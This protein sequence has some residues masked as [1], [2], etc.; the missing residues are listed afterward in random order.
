MKRGD[1]KTGDIKVGNDK[2][3]DIKNSSIKTGIRRFYVACKKYV[4]IA[5]INFANRLAYKVDMVSDIFFSIFIFSILHFLYRATAGI[6]P[7]SAIEKL[8]L[9]QIMWVMFLATVFSG[10]RHKGVS[11]EL[12]KEILS[13]QIAYQLNR[14]YSYA[15]FHFAQHVG[16]LLPTVIFSGIV[17]GIFLYFLVGLPPLYLGPCLLGTI[18]LFIGVV[19]IFLIQFCI[20]LCAFWIGNVD[21]LRWIYMQIMI[22]AGGG[23]VPLAFFPSFI[24]KILMMLPFSNAGYGAARIIV[25]CPRSDLWQYFGLQIFWLFMMLLITR[26]LFKRGIKNVVICGG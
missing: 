17:S 11:K 22:I 8:S 21:P 7:S 23:A 2:N 18:M 9:A 6:T 16:T 26:F 15:M 20:G 10:V 13:G 24:K 4:A 12:N 19:I 1:I 5:K 25:G 14:P 3:G